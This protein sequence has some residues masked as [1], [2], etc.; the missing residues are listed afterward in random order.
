MTAILAVGVPREAVA[1]GFDFWLPLYMVLT[2]VLVRVVAGLR[3]SVVSAVAAFV[4]G[5]IWAWWADASGTIPAAALA[6]LLAFVAGEV[7]RR[8]PRPEPRE[9]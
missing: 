1:G 8:R 3:I 9:R 6:L 4:G 5:T 2:L 7:V